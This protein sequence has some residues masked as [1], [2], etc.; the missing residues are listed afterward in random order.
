MGV[1]LVY[2]N[3]PLNHTDNNKKLLEDHNDLINRDIQ[4]QHPI[5]AIS[6]LNEVLSAVETLLTEQTAEHEYLT[7]K[8]H[9]SENRIGTLNILLNAIKEKVDQFTDWKQDTIDAFQEAIETLNAPQIL[10]VISNNGI[11]LD[12]NAS[13]KELEAKLK[14]VTNNTLYSIRNRSNT[15]NRLY[16]TRNGLYVPNDTLLDSKSIYWENEQST[17]THAQLVENGYWFCHKKTSNEDVYDTTRL[18]KWTYNKTNNTLNYSYPG[19]TDYEIFHGFVSKSLYNNFDVSITFDYNRSQ[20]NESSFSY[21]YRAGATYDWYFALTLY[22]HN[23]SGNFDTYDV[24]TYR[25]RNGT[26]STAEFGVA[27]RKNSCTPRQGSSLDSSYSRSV[28]NGTVKLTATV[29]N[30]VIKAYSFNYNNGTTVYNRSVNVNIGVPVHIGF[31]ILGLSGAVVKNFTITVPEGGE[32]MEE[33][34]IITV[35]N[36]RPHIR[37]NPSETNALQITNDGLF[38]PGLS[39]EADNAVVKKPDGGFFV[40]DTKISDKFGND[41]V[42]DGNK[43]LYCRAGKNYKEVTQE[44]HE[45][46]IGNFIYYSE[47]YNKYLKAIAI[48]DYDANVIGMVTRIIDSNTFEYM[49]SGYFATDIFN[50]ANGYHQGMPLYL[51]D[52]QPGSVTQTQPDISKTVGYPVENTGIII[53]LERGIQYNN[54]PKLGEFKQSTLTYNVRTDGYIRVVENIQYKLSLV[55]SVI[56]AVSESFKNNYMIINEL[57]QTLMF[58]NVDDLKFIMNIPEGIELFI[59]AF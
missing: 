41:I 45:F 58:K 9:E 34:G 29:R 47:T 42:W 36:F 7:G 10:S 38:S 20:N 48:D 35:D 50:S 26:Y 33:E 46:S 24:Y 16:L 17:D 31:G 6:G 54:E 55:G 32:I 8:L 3:K 44:A 14:L 28:A 25:N 37:L 2:F 21:S 59:K 15:V 52:T 27:L 43:V 56:N 11:N 5:Y 49:W 19:N 30:N 12:Y 13:T 40:Q 22:S 23:D 51:S 1:R 39:T 53:S 57:N 18:E 4:D